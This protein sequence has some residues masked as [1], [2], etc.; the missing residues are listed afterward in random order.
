MSTFTHAMVDGIQ[1][2]AAE[3]TISIAPRNGAA[4]DRISLASALWCA[5]SIR[6]FLHIMHATWKLIALLLLISIFLIYNKFRVLIS[7]CL[8]C[9]SR[10]RPTFFC[11]TNLLSQKSNWTFWSSVG[12]GDTR[13]TLT[14]EWKMFGWKT[15]QAKNF[16][17][18]R[19]D[20]K[21]VEPQEKSIQRS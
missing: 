8:V 19:R 17:H 12:C 13:T 20:H 4:W 18:S 5:Q 6:S 7:L 2:Q 9:G 1:R 14:I 16:C 11:K 21:L 10:I 3:Y 15:F